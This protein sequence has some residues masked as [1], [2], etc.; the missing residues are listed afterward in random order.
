MNTRLK[1]RICTG[2]PYALTR[3]E[4]TV[5]WFLLGKKAAEPSAGR[6]YWEI[7]K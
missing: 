3:A 5:Y 6:R 7:V 2:N 1:L 4:A